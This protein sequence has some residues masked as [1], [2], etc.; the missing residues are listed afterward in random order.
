MILSVWALACEESPVKMRLLVYDETIDSY[1]FKDVSLE[2][3][4]D[5]SRL[6]GSATVLRGGLSIEI[7][8]QKGELDW[9]ELGHPVNFSAFEQGGVLIPENYDS[10]AMASIYYNI[11]RS[12]L[13]FR[14]ELGIDEGILKRLPTYY[15]PKVVLIEGDGE[16]M[17]E[18]DNAFYMKITNSERAF[19]VVHHKLFQ[20]IP[21][22]LNGGILTHE[23]THY[24][25]DRLVLE[26]KA[27][28][29]PESDNF[30]LS[31]NE[32]TADFMAAV[33]TG[34]PHY[35]SHTIPEGYF[36]VSRCNG[37]PSMELSRDISN[38][39][40]PDYTRMMDLWARRT[41]PSNFCP[42]EIGL[43]WAAMLY[44]IA[45]ALDSSDQ[46]R[47]KR[48]ALLKV[49]GWLLEAIEALGPHLSGQDTFE[50]WEIMSIFVSKVDASDRETVCDII[51]NRYAMHFDEV[52]GC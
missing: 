49:A 3:I 6:D 38:P 10:L 33:R 35:M 17:L 39:E 4:N 27:G 32:G 29:T 34:D 42:Y 44:E 5:I 48:E 52:D 19:F 21:M 46:D 51:E 41:D 43:M 47:P 37:S 40:R 14:D 30:L 36:E 28:L 23:Y 1:G 50:I 26:K 24:V 12:F 18:K 2:T 22:S 11:E 20:W 25:F 31:I 8:Y 45:D 13:F 9:K 16:K 15:R 7:D